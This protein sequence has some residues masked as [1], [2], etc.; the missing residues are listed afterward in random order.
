MVGNFASNGARGLTMIGMLGLMRRWRASTIV[1]LIVADLVHA[2]RLSAAQDGVVTIRVSYSYRVDRIR[3]E[4]E[5]GILQNR[6]LSMVLSGPKDIEEHWAE[7][8]PRR[9]YQSTSR[10]VLG[11]GDSETGG[12]WH[13]LGPKRLVRQIDYPQNWTIITIAVGGEKSCSATIGHVLKP[14]YREFTFPRVGDRRIAYFTQPR[15]VES[16]CQIE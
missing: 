14:G 12:R 8:S 9:R 5:S 15:V 11:G 13:V 7:Q 2:T 1:A 16:S 4:P 3:P 10:R 6:S